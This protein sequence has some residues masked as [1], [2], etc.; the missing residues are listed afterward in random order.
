LTAENQQHAK[1]KGNFHNPSLY[2]CGENLCFLEKIFRIG[3][4]SAASGFPQLKRFPVGKCFPRI[5]ANTK[6]RD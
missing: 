4:G 5:R 6:G 1:S 2:H 3:F